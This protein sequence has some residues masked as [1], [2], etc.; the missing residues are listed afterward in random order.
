MDSSALPLDIGGTNKAP[1]DIPA[2]IKAMKK[3]EQDAIHPTAK[4]QKNVDKTEVEEAED[5]GDLS[6]RPGVYSLKIS[7]ARSRS[8]SASG[9]EPSSPNKTL[10]TKDKKL[11]FFTLRKKRDSSS[12]K[13]EGSSSP[14]L[15]R[16]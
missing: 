15:P 1:V 7:E 8:N 11:G 13:R 6:N 4:S 3:G 5:E 10:I 2:F 14:G 9:K 12:S 16:K